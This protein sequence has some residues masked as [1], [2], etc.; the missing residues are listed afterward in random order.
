MMKYRGLTFLEVMIVLF[1]IILIFIMVAPNC[2]RARTSGLL[3]QCM[4]N[5]KNMGFALEEYSK[6]HNGRYP[7]QLEEIA[8]KYLNVVP[9]CA[10]NGENTGYINSYHRAIYPDAYTFYCVGKEH[11]YVG[12]KANYP[13][14]NSRTGISLERKK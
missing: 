9:T 13:Q 4:S 7:C 11:G 14:F 10:A 5:C 3:T 12:I 1:I 2:M 6:D 8:P